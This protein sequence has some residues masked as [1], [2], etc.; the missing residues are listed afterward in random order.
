MNGWKDHFEN[1]SKSQSQNIE[2]LPSQHPHSCSYN[3][4]VLDTPF[5]IEFAVKKLKCGKGVV[6]MSFRQ[7]TSS[8]VIIPF[9][10]VFIVVIQLEDI[11][12]CL[13]LG[14]I[15]HPKRFTRRS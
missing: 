11:P 14:V 5:S 15:V 10:S 3:D 12:L 13:K 9:Y 6:Q 8:M 2:P 1:V 7:S 4:E